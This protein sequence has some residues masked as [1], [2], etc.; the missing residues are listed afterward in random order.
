MQVALYARVSTSQQQQ[1]GT[2]ESQRRSLQQHI[3]HHGW[4]LLPVHEDIDD[5]VSGAQ[6]D[7]PALDRLRDAARHGE[8]DAVVILSPDRLA[9]NYAHQWLLIEEF[10]KMHIAVIFLHNPFGDSPQGKLLPQMQGMIA[11]YERA[12]ITERTRRGRLE[13]ARRGE[14]MPWA[15][16]CDGYRYLPK[17]HGDAPQVV[18]EPVEAAVVRGV[19]RLLVE[20][21]LSCRH[22]TKRLNAVNT[23]TPTGKSPVWQTAT[24]RNMLTNRVYAGQARD[25][26]RQLVIP[27]Y[28][29]TAAH[30]LRSLKTGRSYRS[31]SE[32]IWSTAPALITAELFDKAQRQL[33][34]NAATA[35]KMYQPASGRYLLR[36]LVNCGECGLSMV[37]IR[38]RGACKTYYYVYYQC[39]GHSALTVG[40]TTR[41]TAQLIRAERLDAVVWHALV[42]LLQTPSTI[43]HLHQTWATAQQQHLSGLEAQ[44]AQLLQRQ[45]RLERQDQ[46]L[47][48]AYQ[49]EVITLSELQAR[50]QKLTAALHQIEQERQ[51]LAH[52][53][54]QRVHW[55][56]VIENAGTF[57]QFLGDHLDQLSFEER[58]AV[59]QCLIN[60]VIVTG[61]EVDVHF[62]LPFESTPQ[63]SQRLL[64]A[65]EGTPGHFYRLR[66]AHFAIAAIDPNGRQSQDSIVRA[67]SAPMS[68]KAKSGSKS[69]R[70]YRI[71]STSRRESSDSSSRQ[72]RRRPQQIGKY[73]YSRGR[74]PGVIVTRSAG[75]KPI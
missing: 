71:R 50:R 21:Q 3:Q 5:G 38:R 53:R 39:S 24:V 41:C 59:A 36:T 56:R 45:Q 19:Y 6:L 15:Y 10:E 16:R 26:Y 54:Q 55:Q 18:I 64:T 63:V 13:K 65:P 73:N 37:G 28:R 68:L 30:R 49:T 57:R 40:R 33:Q 75:S 60:K 35:H 9:R 34:R 44:Q 74:S 32:W 51:Q 27:Q 20:E 1:E 12:Q 2:I 22:I 7:R 31:E 48:D 43:P 67:A 8:C 42:Q 25:N 17:R 70:P 14:F 62:I 4:A 46:R 72:R 69:K 58:Q 29:K 23:R 47:L 52:T 61:E 66:L 11:E